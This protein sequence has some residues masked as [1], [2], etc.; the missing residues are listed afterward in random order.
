MLEIKVMGKHLLKLYKKLICIIK[1]K[2]QNCIAVD[3]RKNHAPVLLYGVLYYYYGECTVFYQYF[4]NVAFY[5]RPPLHHCFWE[6]TRT[7]VSLWEQ[8][9]RHRLAE[10]QNYEAIPDNHLSDK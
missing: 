8:I 2:T 5:Q 4:I 7:P 9:L 3:Y 6:P 10:N 1:E